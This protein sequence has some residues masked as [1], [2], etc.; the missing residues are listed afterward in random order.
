MILIFILDILIFILFN[1]F[2]KNKIN[3]YYLYF[4][5]DYNIL[6]EYRN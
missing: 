3:I 6:W 1:R 5:S 4:W 2:K